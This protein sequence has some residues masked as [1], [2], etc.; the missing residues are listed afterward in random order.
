[1]ETNKPSRGNENNSRLISASSLDTVAVAVGKPFDQPSQKSFIST[2]PKSPSQRKAQSPMHGFRK[3]LL[4]SS[5]VAFGNRAYQEFF[6]GKFGQI[7]GYL[8][9]Q[10]RLKRK[11]TAMCLILSGMNLTPKPSWYTPAALG[12]MPLGNSYLGNV[13]SCPVTR[14]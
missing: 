10:S 5:G 3:P 8:G 4:K 6:F 11:D 14:T 9:H 1:M 13:R 2:K 7:C 12:D